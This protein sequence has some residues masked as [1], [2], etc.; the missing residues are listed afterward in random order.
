MVKIVNQIGTENFNLLAP[1]K[2]IIVES[3]VVELKLYIK[4]AFL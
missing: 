4:K 3:R 2:L 1:K